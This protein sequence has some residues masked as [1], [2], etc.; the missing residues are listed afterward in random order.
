M[1]TGRGVTPRQV[2][3]AGLCIGC[4][5]CAAQSGHADARMAWDRYGQLKPAGDWRDTPPAGFD[6]TCPFSPDASDEDAIASRL[7]PAAAHADPMVGRF[8]RAYV[9]HVQEGAFRAGGSSG[10]MVSWMAAELLRLGLVDGV[11]H[12]S[13]SDPRKENGFFRYG[14]S[15]T[16]AEVQSGSCSRYYPV[17]LSGVLR[18]IRARPGRYA[19]VGVPCFIKAANLLRCEDEVMRQRIAYT[20]GLF[21]GHMKSAH[22]VDSM[23]MQMRVK[24]DKIAAVDYRIKAQDRP[25]NWYRSRLTLTDGAQCEEDWWHLADGDWGAGYFQ[26]SACNYCDDVVAETADIAFG[27]AWIEPYASCPDGT[28]VVVVRSRE[29]G[30]I[31]ENARRAGRLQLRGV[32]AGFVA[33]TQAAGLRQ[34]REGLAYRLAWRSPA[35]PLR[36]RVGAD[37]SRLGWRRKLVYRMRFAISHW[38]H[39]TLLLAARCHAPALYIGW[40]RA[41]LAI[42]QGLTYS[43]GAFGRFCDFLMKTG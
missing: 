41:V 23:A 40:A 27:D 30:Q 21:C 1:P 11:A 32:D 20:L 8:H 35:L 38:S 29:L 9:G 43:R 36:K 17:E 34:R 4:G 37:A 2:M 12:V 33:Q 28:N 24:T 3:D 6:R 18:A 39:R 13:P 10:G 7:F 42:Y 31:I 5:S 15:R 22:F 25:A 14:I 19:L 26:N 16:I